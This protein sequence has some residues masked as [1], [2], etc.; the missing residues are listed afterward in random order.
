MLWRT[1]FHQVE[2]PTTITIAEI[3]TMIRMALGVTQ[4]IVIS[5]M[6]TATFRRVKNSLQNSMRNEF[7]IR[8]ACLTSFCA[9]QIIKDSRIRW[10]AEETV[11]NVRAG[12]QRPLIG[13]KVASTKLRFLWPK[14]NKFP[15]SMYLTDQNHNFCRNP[16]DDP[17]G[18]W[19]YILGAHTHAKLGV[20][21][22][23]V[24][25]WIYC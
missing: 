23:G 1:Q 19:C 13:I 4:Q 12:L 24:V 22:V 15:R 3:L 2:W 7:Q 25:V 17:E 20:D 8:I 6:I 10:W 9:E 5:G 16:D 11:I 14:F 18:P 21:I